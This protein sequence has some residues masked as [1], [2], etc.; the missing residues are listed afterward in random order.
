MSSLELLVDDIDGFLFAAVVDDG[1][2]IDLYINKPYINGSWA[3]MYLGKIMKIDTKQDAAFVDLGNNL[4][5]YLSAEHALVRTPGVEIPRSGISK[6]VKNGDTFL[7]QIK[8]EGKSHSLYE[9]HKHPRI[10]ANLHVPGGF[11]VYMP[12]S[13]NINYSGNIDEKFIDKL[14]TKVNLDGG[15]KFYSSAVKLSND[16]IEYEVEYLKQHWQHLLDRA[17]RQTGQ[18]GLI[19]VGPIALFRAFMDYGAASFDHIYAGNNMILKIITDWSGKHLPRLATS[20]RLR[21]FKPQKP[22]E[23]LFDTYDLYGEIEKLKSPLV[24]MPQGGTLIIENTSAFTTIDINQGGSSSIE[25]TNFRATYEVA[26]QIKLR[27]LSGAILIDFIGNVP[28][29]TER[30]RL[31]DALES[32]LKDDIGEAQVH[33][34]TRLGIVEITR[35][36][37]SAPLHEKL[38]L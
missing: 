31:L 19:E 23:R 16:E 7:V 6:M 28:L 14:K 18:P 21:L 10:T 26:R 4:V 35:R 8:A 3:S 13:D 38:D 1:Y 11:L 34:F 36:R 20:K 12:H 25:D 5:G 15:W 32:Y 30:K 24:E 27:N 17:D 37:R 22:G 9:N 33:G 2:L 29:K